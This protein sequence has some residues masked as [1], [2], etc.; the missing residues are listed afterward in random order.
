VGQY[1]GVFITFEGLDGCGKTTQLALLAGKLEEKGYSVVRAQEP[2]GT[3]VGREIRKILLDGASAD[4]RPLPELLLYFASRAQNVEEVILPALEAGR[5][6]L[7]DRFTDASMAYQGYGRGL[8]PEVVSA[9][10]KIACRNLVPDVTFLIDIDAETS[11]RRAL[12]RNAAAAADES[13]MER[14]DLDFHRR[15]REGYLA[16][17]KKEPERVVVIDGCRGTQ[18]IA[19]EIWSIAG[20]FLAARKSLKNV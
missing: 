17:S 6:V 8:G 11:V 16:I 10:D 3:R 15:V 7:A 19:A 14:E 5:I 20:K 1:P 12:G 2:G 9:L 18:E 4:L 13:R